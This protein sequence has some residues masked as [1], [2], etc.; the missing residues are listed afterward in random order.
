MLLGRHAIERLQL[1]LQRLQV[2]QPLAGGRGHPLQPRIHCRVATGLPPRLQQGEDRPRLHALEVLRAHRREQRPRPLEFRRA[3]HRRQGLLDR[4]PAIAVVGR[5][6]W[7]VEVGLV[8]EGLGFA[9]QALERGVVDALL[10]RRAEVDGAEQVAGGRCRQRRRRDVAS[11]AFRRHRRGHRRHHLEQHAAQQRR[12]QRRSHGRRLRDR[13]HHIVLPHDIRRGR[14]PGYLRGGGVGRG[15]RAH[16]AVLRDRRRVP[17]PRRQHQASGDA[18]NTRGRGL[19]HRGPWM[20]P[21][22]AMPGILRRAPRR[23][24][25]P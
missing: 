2:H 4:Q 10:F 22:G 15:L 20:A 14:L 17:E 7:R 13:R 11:E 21:V 9:Q 18:K 16:P 19:A 25:M 5:L 3:D 1:L 8:D 12:V 6:P 24:H 23:N